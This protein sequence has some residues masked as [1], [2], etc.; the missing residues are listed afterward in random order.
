[1]CE[2]SLLRKALCGHT[3][4]A[5][6]RRGLSSAPPAAS[7]P[8][9]KPPAKLA[10]PLPAAPA[11]A[12]AGDNGFV[13]VGS[14]PPADGLFAAELSPG[15]ERVALVVRGGRV[16]GAVG[17][18]CPHSRADLAAGDIEDG[19]GPG[20]AAAGAVSVVCPKHRKRFE[21]GLR[22]SC[23]SGRAWMADGAPPAAEFK[24]EWAVPVYD[25]RVDEATGAVLVR[26][27]G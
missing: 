8:A 12:P 21:G 24:A 5:L 11:G 13:V 17:A 4:R 16:A 9:A 15:G 20:C 19:G 26:R 27:R 3:A 18:V 23:D 7:V 14:L 2:T 6:L 22:V 10:K 1:V 25:A